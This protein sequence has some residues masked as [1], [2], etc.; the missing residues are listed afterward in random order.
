MVMETYKKK[1][2]PDV[3]TQPAKADN[4]SNSTNLNHPVVELPGYARVTVQQYALP[5]LTLL[6]LRSRFGGKPLMGLPDR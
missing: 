5:N 3:I 2:A 1:R 4:I 6:G